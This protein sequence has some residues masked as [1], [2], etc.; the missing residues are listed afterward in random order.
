MNSATLT[1]SRSIVFVTDWSNTEFFVLKVT[2]LTNSSSVFFLLYDTSAMSV[3]YACNGTW[4][5][6]EL[7][8]Q[9]PKLRFWASNT[10]N[11]FVKEN[12]KVTRTM[13]SG[14]PAS[15]IFHI[16][17]DQCRFLYTFTILFKAGMFSFIFTCSSKDTNQAI[18]R[19]H[20]PSGYYCAVCTFSKRTQEK[21]SHF[22]T[23]LPQATLQ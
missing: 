11:F 6:N 16:L 23:G 20:M 2:F 8:M 15:H 21:Q 7:F 17:T 10:Y 22:M 13:L 14:I 3:W 19:L 9:K 18:T 1:A 4:L 5:W 12:S